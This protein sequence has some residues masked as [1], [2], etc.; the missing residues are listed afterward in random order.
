M[1]RALKKTFVV[2]L[3]IATFATGVVPAMAMPLPSGPK[4]EVNSDQNVQNVQYRRY[5]R[6]GWYHGYRGY[7]YERYGYRRHYDGYWYPFAAFGA[8]A[9]LGGALAAPR[10]YEPAPRYYTPAP[11]TYVPAGGINPRHVAWCESRYRSYRAYDNT[12][13]PNSGP[14]RQ[15]YSPYF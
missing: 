7:R 1:F 15:C 13:Q 5:Y 8:G 4:L 11:R 14:R 2:A 6:P 12:F 9:L 3:S 10:Y